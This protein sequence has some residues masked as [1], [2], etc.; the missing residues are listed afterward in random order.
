[1]DSKNI[2]GRLLESE[3]AGAGGA[4]AAP[5]EAFQQIMFS[6]RI[7]LNKI[8]LVSADTA[9][10]VFARLRG[11]NQRA[12]IVPCVRG[13]LDT[14]ELVDFGAFDL[15]KMADDDD[16]HHGHGHGHGHGHSH[17]PDEEACGPGC[18]DN[19][20]GKG[21]NHNSDVGSF[22]LVSDGVCVDPLLFARWM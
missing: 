21:G 11:I 17:S 18:A 4:D 3:A 16:D 8:D 12:R 14:A 6:D 1:M 2:L 20:G 22:S 7:V 10:A 19:H 5:D 13:K 9:A 15:H